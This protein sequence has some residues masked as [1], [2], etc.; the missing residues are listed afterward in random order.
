M[1]RGVLYSGEPAAALDQNT[2][3]ADSLGLIAEKQPHDEL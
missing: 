3:E 2:S 1:A